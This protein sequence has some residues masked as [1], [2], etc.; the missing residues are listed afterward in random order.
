MR[1]YL[2]DILKILAGVN[3]LLLIG[4]IVWLRKIYRKQEEHHERLL[5]LRIKTQEIINLLAK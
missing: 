1:V 2:W 5:L 4:V 3:V